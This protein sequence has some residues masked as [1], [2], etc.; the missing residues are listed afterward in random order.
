MNINLIYKG[1]NYNFDLRKDITLKYIQNLVSKLISKNSSTIELMY[2]NS[3]LGEYPETTLLK[4]ITKDDTAISITITLKENNEKKK[5]K[6]L[7]DSKEKADL[8]NISNLKLNPNSQEIESKNKISISF[9]Q[10]KKH[11]K[12]KDYIS[13]N[14]VFEDIYIIKDKEIISLMDNF[15]QKIREYDDILYKKY[16]NNSKRDNIELSIYEK[17]IIDFKDNH[18]NYLKKLINYFDNSEDNFLTGNLPLTQFYSDLKQYDAANKTSY[19]NSNFSI[20]NSNYKHKNNLSRDNMKLKLTD[21]TKNKREKNKLPLLTNNKIPKLKLFFQKN[22]KTRNNTKGN[23]SSSDS[24]SII[25]NNYSNNDF[26]KINSNSNN[27]NNLSAIKSFKEKEKLNLNLNN[28]SNIGKKEKE[29]V[30]NMKKKIDK[31]VNNTTLISKTTSQKKNN[32]LSL[33]KPKNLSENKDNS[34]KKLI[35]KSTTLNLDKKNSSNK[36]DRIKSIYREEKISFNADKINCLLNPEEKKDKTRGSYNSKN[37]YRHSV[38]AL[39]LRQLRSNDIK[40]TNTINNYKK[41]NKIDTIM[42]IIDNNYESSNFSE[43]SGKMSEKR[44]FMEDE[45]NKFT[46]ENSIFLKSRLDR[47]GKRKSKKFGSNAYDFIY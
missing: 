3:N 20:S 21:S 47:T 16:K 4:D 11:K 12:T 15:S 8:S 33:E 38:N 32:I 27:K 40:K 6:V 9:Y 44:N 28:I 5:K 24:D 10:N 14:K 22:E 13:E 34:N 41:L 37:T 43:S 2:K 26:K 36:V 45:N 29:K 23:E 42:E 19:S 25:K 17:S 30:I 31:N 18:I 1:K 7:Q 35:N 39:K 46:E